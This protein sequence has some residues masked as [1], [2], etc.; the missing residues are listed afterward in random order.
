M[1]VIEESTYTS[2]IIVFAPSLV[3]HMP[4]AN[5]RTLY[6]ELIWLARQV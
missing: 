5:G 1:T 3:A 6:V 2:V 4:V